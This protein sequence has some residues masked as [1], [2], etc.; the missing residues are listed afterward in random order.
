M[1]SSTE[2]ESTFS[3]EYCMEYWEGLRQIITAHNDADY[4]ALRGYLQATEL[5]ASFWRAD[6]STTREIGNMIVH[7][8]L[9]MRRSKSTFYSR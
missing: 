4:E 2:R 7:L 6:P 9:A 1:F 8:R 3:D 5:I